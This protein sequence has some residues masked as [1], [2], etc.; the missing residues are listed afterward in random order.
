VE[1]VVP[2][3]ILDGSVERSGVILVIWK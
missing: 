2:I 1:V 3:N